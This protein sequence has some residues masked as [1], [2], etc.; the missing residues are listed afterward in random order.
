MTDT[1]QLEQFIVTFKYNTGLIILIIMFSLLALEL[2]LLNEVL[3]ITCQI[4]KGLNNKV[5]IIFHQALSINN[6]LL[7]FV[8]KTVSLLFAKNY[9]KKICPIVSWCTVVDKNIYICNGFILNRSVDFSRS[10]VNTP[11]YFHR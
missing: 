4:V 8:S 6:V 10:L 7:P 2:L 5:V 11:E 1:R 9:G 3:K